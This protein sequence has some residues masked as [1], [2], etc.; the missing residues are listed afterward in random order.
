MMTDDHRDD[1]EYW[2]ALANR[3]A[4]AVARERTR[5]GVQWL[6]HS[7]AGWVLTSLLVVAV[8]AYLML[9]IGPPIADQIWSNVIAP[10]DEV[11]RAIALRDQPPAIGA[12]LLD[13]RARGLR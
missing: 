8:V 9:P 12:L 1:V 3:I 2:D 10:N 7:R 5:N 6:A 4:T 13:P 11:G